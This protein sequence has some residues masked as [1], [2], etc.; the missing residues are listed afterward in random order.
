MSKLAKYYIE[1]YKTFE[2]V[3]KNAKINLLN[4]SYNRLSNRELEVF[5]IDVHKHF[6]S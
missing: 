6:K 1:N 3:Y 4:S 5:W 2:E